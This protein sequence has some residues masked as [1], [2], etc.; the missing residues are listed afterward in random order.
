MR[1]ERELYDFAVNCISIFHVNT[2]R[3][4]FVFFVVVVRRRLNLTYA[5]EKPICLALIKF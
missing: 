5:T 4:I 1:V 2:I 3:W